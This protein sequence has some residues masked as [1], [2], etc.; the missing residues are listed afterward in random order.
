M[1]QYIRYE[2][3]IRKFSSNCIK[4]IYISVD[5][6]GKEHEKY[7]LVVGSFLNK[8]YGDEVVEILLNHLNSLL[9][10]AI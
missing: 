5:E 10:T 7:D 6:K 3:Q 8:Q 4:G 9:S 2:L 1:K